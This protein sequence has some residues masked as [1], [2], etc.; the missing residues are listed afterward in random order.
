MWVKPLISLYVCIIS[1]P[2]P[3]IKSQPIRKHA[4][5]HGN[6][7][8]HSSVIVYCSYTLLRMSATTCPALMSSSRPQSPLPQTS[9]T[10]T[11]RVP[12]TSPPGPRIPTVPN[13]VSLT[14]SSPSLCSPPKTLSLAQDEHS[15]KILKRPFILVLKRQP[16]TFQKLLH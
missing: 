5:T 13:P 12:S 1:F 15:R 10:E 14:R 4:E 7:R 8:K 11:T 16:K 2:C 3:T 9:T 6:T